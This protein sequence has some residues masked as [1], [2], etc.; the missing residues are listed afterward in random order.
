MNERDIVNDYCSRCSLYGKELKDASEIILSHDCKECHG[1][2]ER[3]IE[4]TNVTLK[5]RM[6]IYRIKPTKK[7]SN[8]F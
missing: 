4:L 7:K 6:D 5:Y 2:L 1:Y 3:D 8:I